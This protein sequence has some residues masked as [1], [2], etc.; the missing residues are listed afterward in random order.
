VRRFLRRRSP[1]AYIPAK[2]TV[3]AAKRAGLSVEAYVERLWNS[4]GTTAAIVE[5]MRDAGALEPTDTVVEIGPGTGR[6]L[7]RVRDIVRPA[8]H[9]IFETAPDWREWLVSEYGV[10]APTSNGESMPTIDRAG[11]I[12]AHGVFVYTSFLVTA[13]YL[14]EI[15][16]AA[17][18]WVVFDFISLAELDD[19]TIADW[20]AGPERYPVVLDREW[21]LST[22]SDFALVDEWTSRYGSGRSRY[23]VLRRD[24][25]PAGS[26]APTDP[27]SVSLGDS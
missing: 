3:R 2:A 6:Y 16:R 4:E 10:E 8:R 17:T 27:S 11:L 20:L 7:A 19:A 21:V 1:S 23:V 26:G 9:V 18:G 22:L 25:D 15:S 24:R 13:R 12:Q 14:A 5:R